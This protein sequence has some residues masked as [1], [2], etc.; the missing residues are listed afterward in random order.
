MAS[1]VDLETLRCMALE[2]QMTANGE[3]RLPD[4][5]LLDGLASLVLPDFS[6]V[7]CRPSYAYYVDLEQSEADLPAVRCEPQEA[8][9]GRF[10]GF[11]SQ[12]VDIDFDYDGIVTSN[13]VGY[14]ILDSPNDFTG[15]VCP[16]ETTYLQ[17]SL[18]IIQD[19]PL[20]LEIERALND[21]QIDIVRL[22]G[23]VAKIAKSDPKHDHYE[24]YIKSMVAPSDV[25]ASILYDAHLWRLGVGLEWYYNNQQIT[26][27]I[28]KTDTFVFGAVGARREGVIP[29]QLMIR[30]G[31]TGGFL[32][33]TKGI[34]GATLPNLE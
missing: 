16:V 2:E 8:V 24:A 20:F 34:R 12:T 18:P 10:G 32:I 26:M 1:A 7:M 27:P 6:P 11:L 28:G 23:L 17:D 9:S 29:R 33:P 22:N 5:Q 19:E 4:W 30:K 15:Y 3:R 25:F 13:K 21:E 31:R 14:L